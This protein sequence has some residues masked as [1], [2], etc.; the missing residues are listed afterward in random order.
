VQDA[1]S[2]HTGGK[3]KISNIELAKENSRRAVGSAMAGRALRVAN[4]ASLGIFG[5]G[6]ALVFYASGGSSMDQFIASTWR[7]VHVERRRLDAFSG[8]PDRVDQDHPEYL[9]TKNMTEEEEYEYVSKTYLPDEEWEST[10]EQDKE[11]EEN[12]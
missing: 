2:V 10:P 3:V 5:V 8:I 12:L 7:W 4:S 9:I 6:T 11:K 1:L